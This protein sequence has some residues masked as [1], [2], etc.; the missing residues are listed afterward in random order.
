MNPNDANLDV[1]TEALRAPALNSS[2]KMVV[3]PVCE[4]QRLKKPK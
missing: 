3:A 4:R 1:N 2:M